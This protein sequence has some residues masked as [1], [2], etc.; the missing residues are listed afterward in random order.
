MER[1]KG[2]SPW[3]PVLFLSRCRFQK[4]PDQLNDGDDEGAQT[5]GAE[6]GGHRPLHGGGRGVSNLGILRTEVPR[7]RHPAARGMRDIRVYSVHPVAQPF[8]FTKCGEKTF[9]LDDFVLIKHVCRSEA[10]EQ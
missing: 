2:D 6:G 1:A 4:G 8:D 3:I 9:F 5:D 10:N 7:R